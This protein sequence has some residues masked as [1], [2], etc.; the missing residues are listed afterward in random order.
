VGNVKLKGIEKSLFHFED[1]VFG[2]GAVGDIDKVHTFWG[3]DFFVFGGGE[4][5]GYTEELEGI[6]RDLGDGEV[7]VDERDAEEKGFWDE[8]EHAV[9]FD[10]PVDENCAHFFVDFELVV[11]VVGVDSVF[12]F[13]H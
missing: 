7:A 9:D 1:L 2:A 3:V 4:H 6:T 5:G 13:L 8:F 11:E 10:E 12:L